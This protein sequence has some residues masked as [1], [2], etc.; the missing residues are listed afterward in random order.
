MTKLYCP[1]CEWTQDHF[2]DDTLHNPIRNL[3]QLEK[4]LLKKDLD[5]IVNSDDGSKRPPLPRR[6]LI[7]MLMQ[8]ASDKV[9]KMR[10]RT[11][12]DWER[13]PHPY[14]PQCDGELEIYGVD[15]DLGH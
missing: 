9:L 8:K 1:H 11:L 5:E 7:A 13:D 15:E 2:W 14:C 4:D 10:W 12:A 3:L 6:T